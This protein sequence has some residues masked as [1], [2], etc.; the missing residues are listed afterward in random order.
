M[1]TLIKIQLLL[2]TSPHNIVRKFGQEVIK[3]PGI[4]EMLAEEFQ[5]GFIASLVLLADLRIFEVRSSTHP[6]VDHVGIGLHV[7]GHLQIGL[8]TLDSGRVLV[9]ARQHSHRDVDLL[10]IFGIQ[11][12]W[13]HLRRSLERLVLLTSRQ[14]R[15]LSSPAVSHNAPLERAGWCEL[16]RLFHDGGD[17]RY[18][19]RRH[20]LCGE[21]VAQ[22]L[23]VFIR[24]RWE[25]GNIARL[26][27][28]KVRDED[29]VLVVG[30]RAGQDIGSLEGL[31]EKSEDVYEGTI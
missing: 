11:E 2:L 31:W 25:D 18:S 8:I 5:Q 6:S 30:V 16:V 10:C 14:T 29:A 13:M 22:V 23:L 28:E 9:L 7:L 24:L 21:E 1:N 26:A 4:L 19:L 20:R 27:L 17:T 3:L 15:D 12:R